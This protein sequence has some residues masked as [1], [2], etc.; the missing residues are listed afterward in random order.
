MLEDGVNR[1]LAACDMKL[2]R[3]STCR[4]L[5]LG[6]QLERLSENA[7]I[8]GCSGATE[9]FVHYANID[10]AIR[11]ECLQKFMTFY[12]NKFRLSRSQWSQDAYVMYATQMF[13]GGTYLEVGG[14]DG[15]THSNTLSLR[16]E[17]GWSGILIEPDPEMF[18]LLKASRGHTDRVINAAISPSGGEGRAQLRRA[19]QLSSLVGYEGRDLHRDIRSSHQETVS[20]DTIDLTEV[21]ASLPRLDYFSLDVEG[22]EAQIIESIDWLRI[23]PPS[24][25]TVEHNYRTTDKTHLRELLEL[26]GYREEFTAHDWLRRGDLWLRHEDSLPFS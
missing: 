25:I 15:I 4:S 26:Q 20:I 19:G 10:K 16:D 7:K 17:L 21:I 5:E 8:I 1:L 9:A 18:S 2:Q 6:Q 11:E 3:V 13:R 12:A 14:A 24:F 22:A 23:R